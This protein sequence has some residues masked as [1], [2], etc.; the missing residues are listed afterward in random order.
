VLGGQ[1]GRFLGLFLGFLGRFGGQLGHLFVRDH[2]V[3]HG[4]VRGRSRGFLGGLF[5]RPWPKLFR[6]KVEEYQEK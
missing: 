6:Q 1:L 2:F 5:L 4:L 3:G